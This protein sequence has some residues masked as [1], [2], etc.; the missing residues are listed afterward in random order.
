MLYDD[1]FI[2]EIKVGIRIE[3]NINELAAVVASL[4]Y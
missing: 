1:Q 3:A 2:Y 4:P